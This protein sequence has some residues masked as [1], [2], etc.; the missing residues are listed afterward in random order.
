MQLTMC[1]CALSSVCV[2]VCV[3]ER[4]RERESGGEEGEAIRLW[5]S[6]LKWTADTGRQRAKKSRELPLLTWFFARPLFTLLYLQLLIPLLFSIN[7]GLLKTKGHVD[8]GCLSEYVCCLCVWVCADRSS[9]FLHII[10][11]LVFSQQ[12]SMGPASHRS[13]T[14]QI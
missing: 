5:V 13:T 8:E 3:R 7:V 2:C 1:L 4:E 10:S 14:G 11:P 12:N 6:S 9:S